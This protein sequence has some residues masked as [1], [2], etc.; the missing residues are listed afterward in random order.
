MMMDPM[1]RLILRDLVKGGSWALT[2]DEDDILVGRSRDAE[3]SIRDRSV[4]K[5]HCR[6]ERRN[7]TYRFKDLGSR[8]GTYINELRTRGGPLEDGDELRVGNFA[9][10]FYEDDDGG[11]D[12]NSTAAAGAL[13]PSPFD[14]VDF[15]DGEDLDATLLAADHPAANQAAAGAVPKADGPETIVSVSP[16]A[17]G[18]ESTNG[19]SENG[20]ARSEGL[21][22]HLVELPAQRASEEPSRATPTETPAETPAGPPP[23]P[24]AR[25][26]NGGDDAESDGPGIVVTPV[27]RSKKVSTSVTPKLPKDDFEEL[28][29]VAES[30]SP[31]RKKTSRK[32]P[33]RAR[34]S[35]SDFDS[36]N[37]IGERPTGRR[38]ARPKGHSSQIL[39]IAA[40]TTLLVGC[41]IGIL[42]GRSTGSNRSAEKSEDA[43]S[44]AKKSPKKASGSQGGASTAA[45]TTTPKKVA[46]NT[47]GSNDGNSSKTGS[48]TQPP[49]LSGTARSLTETRADLTRSD[50]SHRALLR[51]FLDVLE[52]SPTSKE[53]DEYLPLPPDQRWSR[54]RYLEKEELTTQ[55]RSTPPGVFHSFLGRSPTQAEEKALMDKAGGDPVKLGEII[56]ASEL[57]VSLEHTRTRSLRQR[58][59]SLWVDIFDEAPSAEDTSLITRTL[60]RSASD[61][62]TVVRTLIHNQKAVD[63]SQSK[64]TGDS[65]AWV[66]RTYLRLLLRSPNAEERH[67]AEKE[68]GQSADGWQRVLLDLCLRDEYAR[69]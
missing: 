30:P 63:A 27:E 46:P 20:N 65:S 11:P 28:D 31:A 12:A 44:A 3:V 55:A 26:K 62:Q 51:L 43:K 8:N 48:A 54:I 42:I 36:D 61:L 56:T 15:D 19:D 22:D 38:I 5:Q 59:R 68:V 18:V 45:K 13:G 50:D 47:G 7:M 1:A 17:S 37:E 14:D 25:A 35:T 10:L 9:I 69:Y 52:R 2:L 32:K 4:S 57:Y 6:I 34:S 16:P 21:V 60:E 53:L 58:A 66:E 39:W 64:A 40:L 67:H 29:P 41:A 23:I 33:S 49:R 24:A